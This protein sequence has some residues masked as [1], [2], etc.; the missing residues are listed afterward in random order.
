MAIS[1]STTYPPSTSPPYVPSQ[2]T[3]PAIAY[4]IGHPIAHSSSPSLHVS[5]STTTSI[6]YRQVL[7]ES[8]DLTTFLSHLRSHPS[9][10]RLLGSG[11]TM[12]HKVNVIPHLDQLTDEGKAIGAVNTI[13]LRPASDGEGQ[14]YELWG[15][16]TDCIGIRDA[17]MNNLPS[18]TISSAK[19]KPALV[20]GGG[21]TCRA[22]VYAL[23]TYFQ[24]S[25]IYIVNRDK[26]EVDAV[27]SECAARSSADNLIHV[28]NLEQAE[29][30]PG[31]A[32]I[33]SAIPDFTPSTESEKTVRA[34][35][36]YFMQKQ[37]SGQGAL[38]EMCYHPSPNTQIA[39]LAD[40]CGWKVIGGIEAMIGQGLEQAKLW[41][42]VTVDEGVIEEA[43]RAV[44]GSKV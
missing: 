13:F 11:V 8:K 15:T 31:P 22:A 42:G 20:V 17:F 12:P 5:I 33:V 29:S 27:L 3:Q 32:L 23:Q 18:S 26:A 14:G 7:V 6:P 35:L 36:E 4:L 2:Y 24:A 37:Q 30:L 21:G 9:S 10:P 28:S 40:E 16:N 39:K 25:E 1:S 38:L 19:G 34:L 44:G 41:A 43:R